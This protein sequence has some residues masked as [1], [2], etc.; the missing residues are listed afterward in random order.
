M[1]LQHL[2]AFLNQLQ[3]QQ[4]LLWEQDQKLCLLGADAWDQLHEGEIGNHLIGH[5]W[6]ARCDSQ[7]LEVGAQRLRSVL[8]SAIRPWTSP[9][10][11]PNGRV[12]IYAE[13][14]SGQAELRGKIMPLFL[15]SLLGHSEIYQSTTFSAARLWA[16]QIICWGEWYKKLWLQPVSITGCSLS[17]A[18]CMPYTTVLLRKGFHGY[19]AQVPE[20]EFTIS[21]LA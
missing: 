12:C 3:R 19:K 5:C 20:P 10:I 11:S 4:L 15:S 16:E 8:R 13:V 7:R 21:I 17:K 6:D 18:H 1:R 2:E 14:R 9:F